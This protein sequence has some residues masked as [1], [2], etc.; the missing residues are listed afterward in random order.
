MKKK[1]VP[2]YLSDYEKE[3]LTEIA[4]KWGVSLSSAIVR[5]IREAKDKGD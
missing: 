4:E 2:V 3:K 1:A 5:L